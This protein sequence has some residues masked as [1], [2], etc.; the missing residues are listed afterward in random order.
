MYTF[1]NR[2]NYAQQ[3][4]T[5]PQTPTSW[6]QKVINREI[7]WKLTVDGLQYEVFGERVN[8]GEFIVDSKYKR[9]SLYVGLKKGIH[10][11]DEVLLM[12]LADAWAAEVLLGTGEAYR[13]TNGQMETPSTPQVTVSYSNRNGT[14][15]YP[16]FP[17]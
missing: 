17:S 8:H 7:I 4:Q 11:P 5:A 15:S 13:G 9:A 6:E 10:A 3:Q 2:S 1:K 14:N 16:Y 12:Q